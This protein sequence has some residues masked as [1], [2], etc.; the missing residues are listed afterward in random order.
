MELSN[1]NLLIAAAVLA[2][3]AFGVYH[4]GKKPAV[5]G[6]GTG[7]NTGTGDNAGGTVPPATGIQEQQPQKEPLAMQR[8]GR[9]AL[10]DDGFLPQG[11]WE[12]V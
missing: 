4:F 8:P 5:D 2:V 10:P 3:I 9:I 11:Y 7:S 1:R 6:S 12:D